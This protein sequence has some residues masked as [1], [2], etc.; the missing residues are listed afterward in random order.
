M[1]TSIYTKTHQEYNQ[2]EI[3]S[4]LSLFSSATGKGRLKTSEFLAFENRE[5]IRNN[6]ATADNVDVTTS[7]FVLSYEAIVYLTH[8]GLDCTALN[9]INLAC[10]SQV[11]NQL[12][13]DINEELLEITDNS[14]RATMFFEEGKLSLLERTSE[15]RRARHTYLSRLKAFVE[16]LQVLSNFTV[17]SSCNDALKD[18]IGSL[19]SNQ[20]LYCESTTISAVKNT[21]N[22]ILVTDDQFLFALANTEGIPNIGLT[23]LLAQSNLCWNEL[24][25]ASKKLKNMNYGN[26][27][28]IQLYKRIVDQMLN[29]ESNCEKASAEIQAWIISDSDGEATSYHEDI[30]ITL[31]REVVAQSLDYLNP[32]GFLMDI[33]LNIW[34]KRNP[35][36]IQK[37]IANV[38][39]STV[40]EN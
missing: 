24:L 32:E 3:R 29:Q 36:F 19:F 21:P 9:G 28:P 18:F 5:K 26:Y 16:A 13:N 14:Q 27:L 39:K 22:A 17:F 6:L 38:F 37:C 34:E 11:R 35:G 2:L 12:L 1:Y 23:N 25:A 15:M 33:V 20:K 7:V 30:V 4:P 10:S 31:Y 8:L 40:D